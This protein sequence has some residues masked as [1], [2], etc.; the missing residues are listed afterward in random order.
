MRLTKQKCQQAAVYFIKQLEQRC[1]VRL[2][3]IVSL[4][5]NCPN[6]SHYSIRIAYANN[7]YYIQEHDVFICIVLSLTI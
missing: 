3:E 4:S 1:S 7:Y 6:N 5:W 2:Q